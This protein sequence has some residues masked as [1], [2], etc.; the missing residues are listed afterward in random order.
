MDRTSTRKKQNLTILSDAQFLNDGTQFLVD[1]LEFL[2]DVDEDDAVGNQDEALQIDA[3]D[4][5]PFLIGGGDAAGDAS[6][7]IAVSEDVPLGNQDTHPQIDG[8][9]GAGDAPLLI[10]ERDVAGDALIQIASGS[11]HW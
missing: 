6:I 4:D 1:G 7:H 8:G 10:D 5:A 2:N 3:G 11:D 9:D